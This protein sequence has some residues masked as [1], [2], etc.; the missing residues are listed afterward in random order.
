VLAEFIEELEAGPQSDFSGTQRYCGAAGR[1][2]A[3][4][5]STCGVL[6]PP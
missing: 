6:G 1:D 4:S 2:R 3:W 5:R